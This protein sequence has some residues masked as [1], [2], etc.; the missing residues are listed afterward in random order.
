MPLT[1]FAHSQFVAVI[2]KLTFICINYRLGIFNSIENGY[3]V[4]ADYYK[5]K[6]SGKPINIKKMTADLEREIDRYVPKGSFT[7]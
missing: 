2:I 1:S 3:F 7:D 4:F 5:I 6:E